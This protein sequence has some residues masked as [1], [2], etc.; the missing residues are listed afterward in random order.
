MTFDHAYTNIRNFLSRNAKL[1]RYTLC[2]DP[3]LVHP[4]VWLIIIIIVRLFLTRRNTTDITRARV[5]HTVDDCHTVSAAVSVQSRAVKQVSLQ[6]D[7]EGVDRPEGSAYSERV[8]RTNCAL[9]IKKCASR[10]FS[11]IYFLSTSSLT[12]NVVFNLFVCLQRSPRPS[13][14]IQGALLLRLLLLRGGEG[15]IPKNCAPRKIP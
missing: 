4:S 6:C 14:R 15:R 10:I 5:S 11:G 3:M 13:S 8:P 12:N 7:F 9:R 1:A 2:D